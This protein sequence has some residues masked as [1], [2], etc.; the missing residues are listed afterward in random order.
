[1][2]SGGRAFDQLGLDANHVALAV[3]DE[4]DWIGAP[5]LRYVVSPVVDDGKRPV[6]SDLDRLG[7]VDAQRLSTKG[8]Q[9]SC[10][11]TLDALE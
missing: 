9:P 3:H 2:T 6:V 8:T 5:D 7:C 11:Q 10:D 4:V 1:M